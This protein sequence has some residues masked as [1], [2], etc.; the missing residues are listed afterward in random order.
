MTTR[1]DKLSGWTEKTLQST[2]Q[3][4]TCTLKWVMVTVWWFAASLIHYGLLNP[5]ETI[6]SA[7]YAQH[8]ERR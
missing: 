3:S 5:R 4:Q 6:T 8:I 7:K 1:D 2:S